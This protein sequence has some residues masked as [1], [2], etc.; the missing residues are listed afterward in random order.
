MVG[1]GG[2]IL[3]VVE[4]VYGILLCVFINYYDID[5][6]FGFYCSNCL[7]IFYVGQLCYMVLFFNDFVVIDDNVFG[8]VKN[9][10]VGINNFKNVVLCQILYWCDEKCC[11]VN[12]QVQVVEVILVWF[13][14]F[15]LVVKCNNIQCKNKKFGQ[16]VILWEDGQDFV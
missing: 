12:Q 9:W 14:F 1:E 5:V 2:I 6:I 7:V 4:S 16:V 11:D 15:F 8:E 10:I 3:V 13:D